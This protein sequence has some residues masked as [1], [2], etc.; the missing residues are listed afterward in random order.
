MQDITSLTECDAI[1]EAS[2]EEMF[3]L[4][5]RYAHNSGYVYAAKPGLKRLW[6]EQSMGFWREI[7]KVADRPVCVSVAFAVID[8][9]RLAFVDGCSQLVDRKMIRDWIDGQKRDD[10]VVT[11][12]ANFHHAFSQ[13]RPGAA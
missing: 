11:N 9:Q 2:S 12:A 5:V 8:G 4:W 1:V 10:T 7:G 3:G 6:Q 13:R